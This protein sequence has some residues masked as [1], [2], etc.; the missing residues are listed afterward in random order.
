MHQVPSSTPETK[1]AGWGEGRGKLSGSYRGF[2]CMRE[3]TAGPFL[4]PSWESGAEVWPTDRVRVPGRLL[5]KSI[6]HWEGR[7]GFSVPLLLPASS[8]VIPG[9]GPDWSWHQGSPLAASAPVWPPRR[10]DVASSPGCRGLVSPGSDLAP[11]FLGRPENGAAPSLPPECA[12]NSQA[13]RR[14]VGWFRDIS[15]VPEWLEPWLGLPEMLAPVLAPVPVPLGK[16]LDPFQSWP[17]VSVVLCTCHFTLLSSL[18][19]LSLVASGFCSLSLRAL[20]CYPCVTFS[21]SFSTSTLGLHCFCRYPSCSVRAKRT[22]PL[23]L[24]RW[25]AWFGVTFG[26]VTH[27]VSEMVIRDI[28]LIAA[29]FSVFMEGELL[30]GCEVVNGAPLF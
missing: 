8:W 15:E 22:L 23:S 10:R 25:R 14:A 27:T 4:L 19:S 20:C 18:L 2:E 24:V 16:I 26:A 1:R 3:S 6:R 28:L 9:A 7:R 30:F 13:R 29:F 12:G 21:A 5:R 17:V 11:L